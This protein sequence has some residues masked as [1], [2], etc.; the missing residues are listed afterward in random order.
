MRVKIHHEGNE[1]L[2]IM[3][4]VMAAVCVPLWLW[5]EPI[6]WPIAVTVVLG[7]LFLLTLNFFRSPRRCFAGDADGAVVASADGKVVA[8]EEVEE[9]E[10]LH[11][12]CIQLSVFMSIFNV[13]ANWFPV[14]GVV[15][16]STHHSGRFQAAYLPKSSSENERSS[17]V[18][19]TPDG[20]RVLV[21]QVA[22]AVA[23]RIVT[24]AEAG[25]EANIEDHLGFIKFGSRVDLYLPLNTEIFVKIGDST[26]GGITQVGK[27]HAP[28]E[29][30]D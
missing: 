19:R 2:L 13:H 1:I 11:C 8:L 4:C 26:V 22:G 29:S 30:I 21:R 6:G 25:D 14:N 5:V 15:E 16:S 28:T 27:L 3:L 23:R 10:F 24:Y 20:N 18:I 9:N 17:V 12:R 7:I